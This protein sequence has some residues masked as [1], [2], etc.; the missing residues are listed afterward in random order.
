MRPG[1]RSPHKSEHV[2]SRLCSLQ[3]GPQLPAIPTGGPQGL[4]GA[5]GPNQEPLPHVC[6][7]DV[8]QG[9]QLTPEAPAGA[10]LDVALLCGGGRAVAGGCQDGT[11]HPRTEGAGEGVGRGPPRG[12]APRLHPPG[13]PGEL[14]VTMGGGGPGPGGFL[15]QEQGGAWVLTLQL[16]WVE[17]QPDVHGQGLEGFV[18]FL[19]GLVV[20]LRGPDCGAGTGSTP[21]L[22]GGVQVCLGLQHTCPSPL[23]QFPP[24]PP[25]AVRWV[26]SVTGGKPAPHLW[27]S[28]SPPPPGPADTARR[29]HSPMPTPSWHMGPEN[30]QWHCYGMENVTCHLFSGRDS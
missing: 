6:A 4:M 9:R 8:G 10:H 14:G 22:Q 21:A 28:G 18:E 2:A 5:P 12:P 3:E 19:Q 26:C 17:G 1:H 20:H 24:L 11:G 7:Q 25:R 27:L 23:A 30:A 15:P 29:L 16:G 13:R